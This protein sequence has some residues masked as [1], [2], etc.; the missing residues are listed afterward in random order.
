MKS[1]LFFVAGLVATMWVVGLA[2]LPLDYRLSEFGIVPRTIDGLIGVPLSPFLHASF[3]HLL[4]N[5]LPVAFLGTLVAIQ[6]KRTFLLATVFIVLGGGGALWVVG[7]HGTHVGAS[8]LIFGY[9]G[10]LVA[11]A[12]YNRSLSSIVVAVVMVV[13]YGG[14]V[15]GVLP[16]TSDVSW[17]GHLTGLI[18]GVLAARTMWKRD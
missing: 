12:W 14:V 17:E 16:S 4:V 1:A 8:G 10:Y 13:V 7:R 15:F 18:A 5:S 2:N 6:G 11:R 3:D 9:F